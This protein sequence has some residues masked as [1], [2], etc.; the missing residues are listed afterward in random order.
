MAEELENKKLRYN[1][2]ANC[3][4]EEELI[5]K[6]GVTL[7]QPYDYF[8]FR[9]A[10]LTLPEGASL[11]NA[12]LIARHYP[13]TVKTPINPRYR[14]TPLEAIYTLCKNTLVY[15]MQEAPL[16]C[17][18][19]E[20]GF[21]LGDGCYTSLTHMILTGDDTMVRK[22]IDDAFASAFVSDTLM[23][24]LNASFMQEIAE[25]PLILVRLV[26]WHYRYTKDLSYLSE[27]YPKVT[28]LL[29]A[30]RRDYEK[31]GLLCNLDK[32][33]VVEWP[34]NFRDGYDVDLTSG[35]LCR[36]A[37]TVMNA[38]YIN[39]IRAAN[40]MAKVLS[41][42][43]YREEAPLVSA[44]HAAFYDSERRRFRDSAETEHT[45]FLSNLFAYAYGLCPNAEC[46]KAIFHTVLEKKPSS[47]SIFGAFVMLEGLVRHDEQDALA[48][49][50][51]D[52]NAWLA[53]LKEDATV[54]ME[55]WQ[56]DKKWNTSLFHPTL[57]YAALFLADTDLTELLG[58][59][60]L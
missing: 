41:K 56:R 4:Y 25:F 23:C 30:Y 53:M 12:I 8:A 46:E 37:H 60:K 2:R 34:A 21:Y 50:L 59:F 51:A 27:N 13:S 39:A 40:T 7:Y 49:L 14:K 22:V 17:L 1:L 35:K 28:T 31:N 55:S 36:E 15:G 42:A 19:R 33:C 10:E 9:Y 48:S 54:T 26:L 20:K 16:D 18:E 57:S 52:E 24:C 32:W 43:P 5:L 45:S 11:E 3:R 38:Y 6:E 58:S 47:V 44:F 29:D